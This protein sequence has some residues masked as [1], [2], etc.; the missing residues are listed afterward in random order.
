MDIVPIRIG[1]RVFW[2]LDAP[3]V[4]I[5]VGIFQNPD[6]DPES[7]LSAAIP[8]IN[9]HYEEEGFNLITLFERA[10]RIGQNRPHVSISTKMGE[11]TLEVIFQL[12]TRDVEFLSKELDYESYLK[13]K[14]QTQGG[15][16]VGLEMSASG[17]LEPF[18]AATFINQAN[19]TTYFVVQASCTSD[20]DSTKRIV[21]FMIHLKT[22]PENLTVT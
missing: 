10:M 17:T 20:E 6:H 3:L 12:W 11:T 22:S 13:I 21:S 8:V 7:K 18:D 4:E 16:A 5:N 15:R 1:N 2:L 19:K 14:Q 9:L